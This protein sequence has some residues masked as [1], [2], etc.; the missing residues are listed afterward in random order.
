MPV[1]ATLTSYLPVLL[2][3]VTH[4]TAPDDTS[5]ST[6]PAGQVDYLS[7][8]WREEDVWSSW[9]SMTR[10]KNAI[11]NGMRLENASWRTWWKQRNKLKTISPETLNWLKDSDVTWLYGPL[12]IGS[13]WSPP[14]RGTDSLLKSQ[15]QNSTD[16]I[17]SRNIA[18]TSRLPTKP[19]LKRR[20]IS[21]LLSLPS[22]HWYDQY[23]SDE[24]HDD[25]DG[26]GGEDAKSQRPPLLHTKSDTHISWRG[27]AHRK[28]SPPRIIAEEM[29]GPSIEPPAVAV[30]ALTSS[31][32]S[33]ATS[34]HELSASTSASGESSA[35]GASSDSGLKKKHI[36]FN[37]FVEQCIAIEKPKSKRP[38]VGRRGSPVFSYDDGYEEDSEATYEDES[39]D[40]PSGFYA[41]SRS[42]NSDSDDDDDDVIEMRSS[43]SRASSVSSMHG[44]PKPVSTGNASSHSPHSHPHYRPPLMRKA[45]TG[46][47]RVTIAPIAPTILKSTGVGN[48]L[49]FIGAGR[50][51]STS[52][53]VDLVYA[54]PTHS[55]YSRP[56]TPDVRSPAAEDVYHHRESYFTIGTSPSPQGRSP[57]TSPQI[58]TVAAL[59]PPSLSSSPPKYE[60]ART[61]YPRPS[62]LEDATMEDTFDFFDGPTE[63]VSSAWPAGDSHTRRTRG[64]DNLQD[65]FDGRPS[66]VVRYAEGGASSVQTGRSREDI[67]MSYSPG[68]SPPDAPM[69]VVNEVSGATEER[70]E[71]SREGSPSFADPDSPTS[72]PTL[73]VF[74]K[75]A[76]Y[77][78]KC[79]CRQ[80]LRA[81]IQCSQYSSNC[82]HQ[83][84]ITYPRCYFVDFF[85]K[86]PIELSQFTHDQRSANTTTC[87][88][89]DSIGH[90]CTQYGFPDGRVGGYLL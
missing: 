73:Y 63:D 67:P 41:G 61:F 51:T 88:I 57:Q 47:D 40:S 15:R 76:A 20:S 26:R 24:E 69:V 58:P 79:W 52:K 64:R 13:D 85:S 82:E 25:N 1:P 5:F 3:S 45:S 27:R 81:W 62:D 18:A 28:D 53:E 74:E 59:P 6:L 42:D 9:R 65:D 34:E 37:T 84:D 77:V 19:I 36:S 29:P 7:H 54:P 31:D 33:H 87:R 8:E 16:A 90:I 71:R 55:N 35:S 23:G 80:H 32:A 60:H 46:G 48:N 78:K 50:E 22:S 38:P 56:G 11:A 66:G 14:P 86:Q 89:P 70:T 68:Q 43:R 72:P 4:S 39:Y 75:E 49:R 2:V 21:Q 44:A 10:Q 83:E 17:P 12:H 30:G